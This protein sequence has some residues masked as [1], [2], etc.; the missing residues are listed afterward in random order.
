M[1]SFAQQHRQR[2]S[3]I[4]VQGVCLVAAISFL[5]QVPKLTPPGRS[6][7]SSETGPRFAVIDLGADETPQFFNNIGS[8]VLYGPTGYRFWKNGTT[9]EITLRTVVGLNDFDTMA[10]LATTTE[11]AQ[12]DTDSSNTIYYTQYAYTE[13][14]GGVPSKEPDFD[15][16]FRALPASAVTPYQYDSANPVGIDNSY[17][18]YCQYMKSYEFLSPDGG[19]FHMQFADTIG[20]E[21]TVAM[22]TYA[23]YSGLGL[24]AGVILMG[25]YPTDTASFFPAVVGSGGVV[26]GSYAL[27][28]YAVDSSL[29]Y[30]TPKDGGAA[31]WDGAIEKEPGYT[32]MSV[33]SVGDILARSPGGSVVALNASLPPGQIPPLPPGASGVWNSRHQTVGGVGYYDPGISGTMPISGSLSDMIPSGSGWSSVSAGGFNGSINDSGEIAGTAT[34][35]TTVGG[36]TTTATHGVMLIPASFKLVNEY[37][38]SND[39]MTGWDS[40][41]SSSDQN[42]WTICG[43]TGPDNTK[44][45]LVLPQNAQNLGLECVV[46]DTDGGYSTSCIT[47]QP[48]TLQGGDNNLDIKGVQATTFDATNPAKVVSRPARIVLRQALTKEVLIVLK[49]VVLPNVNVTVDMFFCDDNSSPTMQTLSALPAPYPTSY[50]SIASTVISN[51][52]LYVN[53][54][55]RVL[56]VPGVFSQIHTSINAFSPVNGSLQF[57][58]GGVWTAYPNS[59]TIGALIDASNVLDTIGSGG[60]DPNNH[61]LR[62]FVVKAMSGSALGGDNGIALLPSPNPP[63]MVVQAGPGSDSTY[64]ANF[65]NVTCGHEI[66]H[67]LGL[68]TQNLSLAHNKPAYRHDQGPFPLEEFNSDLWGTPNQTGLMYFQLPAQN[69]WIRHEDWQ[70]ANY[71]ATQNLQ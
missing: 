30:Y 66:G 18:V 65:F 69:Y 20:G 45:K 50:A 55:S 60:N 4:T 32:L 27:A 12:S 29:L 58:P 42:A 24:F 68:A 38:S 71:Y 28:P 25:T 64:A 49:V 22:G 47:L 63:Y 26:L 3:S 44:I 21:G 17:K 15:S 70:Q 53:K 57:Q 43:L 61:H 52:N 39:V 6:G 7:P 16:V 1:F 40:A 56:F 11:H 46:D 5:A 41:A 37:S 13:G 10:G 59:V 9:R 31:Y 14:N 34:L 2:R 8:V 36:T 62:I 67:E 54:Q 35:T 51:M 23:P 33:N 48:V 19:G